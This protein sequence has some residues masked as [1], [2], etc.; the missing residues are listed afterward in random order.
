MIQGKQLIKH[1]G[2]KKNVS[3]DVEIKNVKINDNNN[4]I[5]GSL[6]RRLMLSMENNNNLYLLL[7]L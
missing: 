1:E 2:K 6:K 5:N 7:I 3:F 4:H